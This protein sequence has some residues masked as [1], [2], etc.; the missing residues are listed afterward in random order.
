MQAVGARYS[1]LEE[2]LSFASCLPDFA[3]V[4]KVRNAGRDCSIASQCRKSAKGHL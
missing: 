3:R 1:G 2:E 4:V